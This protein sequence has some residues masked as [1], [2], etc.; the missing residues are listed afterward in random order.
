[1]ARYADL[2][3]HIKDLPVPGDLRPITTA[4][5][6]ELRRLVHGLPDD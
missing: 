4:E 5:A 2:Q 6:E 3:H 1:M